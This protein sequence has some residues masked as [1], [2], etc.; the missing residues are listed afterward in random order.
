MVLYGAGSHAILREFA[1]GRVGT[2][3]KMQR[4]LG[5]YAAM[6]AFGIA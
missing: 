1:N 6:E 4:Y 5:W 2:E 3:A